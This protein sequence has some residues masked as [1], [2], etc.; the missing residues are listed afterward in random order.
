MDASDLPL[1]WDPLSATA[2]IWTG[3]SPDRLQF[4]ASALQEV[5][6]PSRSRE[7]EQRDLHLLVRPEDAM[8][9]REIVGQILEAALPE[10]SVVQ[11]AQG[12]WYDEPVRSYLFAWLPAIV[13]LVAF[14]LVDSF[15]SAWI[16]RVHWN[17]A[18]EPPL[19]VLSFVSWIGF[20]WML[21]QVIRYEIHP[22]RFILLSFLPF[23]FVWY[24][25][26]RYRRREGHQRLPI[27]VRERI[28]PRPSA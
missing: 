3:Q 7:D 11:P 27:T 17:S 12:I 20:L 26:E 16:D 22:W 18:F 9:A 6:I 19:P 15:D 23:S 28:P 2:E 8:Q 5:G 13:C 4:L 24:Y 10:K 14:I 1:H 21:Y 25:Y